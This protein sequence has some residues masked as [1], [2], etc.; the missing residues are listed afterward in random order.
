[1]TFDGVLQAGSV[2][3]WL[4]LFMLMPTSSV[5]ALCA[6]VLLPVMMSAVLAAFAGR[7][8]HMGQMLA[9]HRGAAQHAPQPQLS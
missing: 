8:A 6:E 9:L 4:V 7:S 2:Q 3:G 5:T 1:M